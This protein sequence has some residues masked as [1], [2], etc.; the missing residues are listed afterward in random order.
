MYTDC[1]VSVCTPYLAEEDRVCLF[2]CVFV[3]DRECVCSCLHVSV[4]AAAYPSPH[5]PAAPTE[6]IAPIMNGLPALPAVAIQGRTTYNIAT[7]L[8]WTKYYIAAYLLG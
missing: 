1:F 5:H 8:K 4:E 6:P 2:V 3:C 7:Y